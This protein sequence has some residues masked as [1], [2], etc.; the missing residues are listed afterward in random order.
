MNVIRIARQVD[1]TITI[2]DDRP[3]GTSQRVT[4]ANAEV[5]LIKL[6][7]PPTDALAAVHTARHTCVGQLIVLVPINPKTMGETA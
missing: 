6:G 5:L 3:H 1:N 7:V 2:H 4:P